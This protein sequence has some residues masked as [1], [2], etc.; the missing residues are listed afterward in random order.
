MSLTVTTNAINTV[1]FNP[2]SE[3]AKIEQK[4]NYSKHLERLMNL[5]KIVNNMNAPKEIKHMKE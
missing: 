2:H 3:T 1:K 4:Y 5:K